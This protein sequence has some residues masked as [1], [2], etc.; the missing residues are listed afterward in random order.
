MQ[1]VRDVPGVKR[2]QRVPCNH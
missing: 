1:H 2:F